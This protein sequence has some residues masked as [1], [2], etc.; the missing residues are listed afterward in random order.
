[1]TTP[2]P[3]A[4][5]GTVALA[6]LLALTLAS[7]RAAAQ[8]AAGATAPAAA[9]PAAADERAGLQELR[10]TTLALIE[11]L[12]EQGLLSRAKADELIR[13][14]QQAGTST[15]AS[16][17]APAAAGAAAGAAVAAGAGA[18][19]PAGSAAPANWGERPASV[20]RVP[21]VP[22]S[23]RA[24]M[25]EE[26]RNDVLA[27]AREEN[28]IDARQL[29]AWVRGIKVEG[30]VRVRAEAALLDNTNTPPE[31][32]QL[33][34]L[35]GST[36]AWSPDIV[37][38]RTDRQR[39]TL[40]ARLGVVAKPGDDVTAGVRITSGGTTPVAS[41]SITMGND[42]QR[43][44]VTLDRAYVRWEPRQNLRFEAGR[45]ATPFYGTDLLWPDDLAVEGVSGHGELDLARGLYAFTTLGAFPLQEFQIS[46]EDKWLYGGQFGMNWAI[47]GDWGLQG[48]VA[49]YDFRKIEGVREQGLPPTG[50]FANT[51]P[52]Q[53][54]Q[55]PATVRQKGNTLIDINS[56]DS[57]ATQAVWG[58]ASRFKPFNATV[59]L[60]NRMFEPFEM[61]GT[62]DYVRNTG[63]ERA[64][65][66]RRFGPDA[67]TELANLAAMTTG[68]QVRMDVGRLR[69]QE[70]GDWQA[71]VG[72]RRFER[73]A[74]PDAF[75]DTTWNL[76]G[77]NYKG[78]TVGGW[79]EIDRGANVGA[80]WT[81]TRN[82]D[83]GTAG[84]DLSSA[85][86]RV[87][88]LQVE[89][90]VKF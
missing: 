14:A 86:L 15:A 84:A 3:T 35:L 36:P 47:S 33:Q 83:D 62:V 20:V 45:T 8:N 38:T 30:D 23:V 52:Y 55:Y 41:Q 29:P 28:W 40:R 77:T 88:V 80:R 72:W 44:V 16:T 74:W 11:A 13:K 17:G 68:W 70:K 89:T 27:T 39:L 85:K 37:N 75:T 42:F 49:L 5:P 32:Y 2:T 26:I 10:A 79:Y 90:N 6:T 57:T 43:T 56:P 63:F 65:I 12:V 24:Q 21:Y 46:G 76:G 1:M 51:T 61:Q 58:L 67:P 53:L 73:D 60:L 19:A 9:A 54:S 34:N 66:L 87:D 59:G 69:M 25:K 50:P 4:R 64:D 71:Y 78:Y 81:S 48:A 18:G 22:E 82:L 31:L 7:P